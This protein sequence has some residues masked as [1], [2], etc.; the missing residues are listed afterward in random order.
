MVI[1][2]WPSA[3]TVSI[4]TLP[5][6]DWGNL[7]MPERQPKGSNTTQKAPYNNHSQ[8][9]SRP[10]YNIPPLSLSPPE[11]TP[12]SC[13]PA[14]GWDEGTPVPTSLHSLLPHSPVSSVAA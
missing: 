4:G 11:G 13:A 10:T 2:W 3:L 5:R 6:G 7:E 12:S 9:K 8:V 14:V 1:P